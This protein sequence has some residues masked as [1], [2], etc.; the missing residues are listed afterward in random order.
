MSAQLT[1]DRY[2][3]SVREDWDRLVLSARGRHFMFARA[4]MDY[5]ADRF[6]DASLVVL[7]NGRPL[8]ALPASR[9]GGEVISH[10]GLTFGGLISGPE[11]TTVLAVSALDGVASAL[12]RDGARRL[13]YK[14][15]PHI[16]HLAPAEEDLFALHA[17][18]A[19]L[20]RREVSAAI[21]PG[22]RPAYSDERRRASSTADGP[23]SWSAKTTE[24]RRSGAGSGGVAR[25][26]QR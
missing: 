1:V 3:D 12:R 9:H 10:G 22:A 17:A 16:Y 2:E 24:S 25:C 20:V 21:P 13:T 19:R 15:L 6:D 26:A 18:G 14:A 7:R 11:L 5:H 8:A 4:Y 23:A